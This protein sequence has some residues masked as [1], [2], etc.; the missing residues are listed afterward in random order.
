MAGLRKRGIMYYAREYDL[1]SEMNRIGIDQFITSPFRALASDTEAGNG[2]T[3]EVC[4]ANPDRF[5]ML[6]VVNPHRSGRVDADF[7]PSASHPQ[8]NGLKFHCEVHAY[9]TEGE[10][11]TWGWRTAPGK[12]M[13]SLV[14]TYPASVL[15]VVPKLADQYPDAKFIIVRHFGP[16]NLDQAPPLIHDRANVY[17]DT[18]VSLLPLGTIE[19]LVREL[20]DERI[21]FGTDM[22]YLNGGQIGKV[23]LAELDGEVKKKLLAKYPKRLFSL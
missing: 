3:L 2:E 20:G 13:P 11:Y 14:H 8:V 1:L 5:L 17:S 10:G 12:G 21:L 16:E 23:L 6:F 15:A 19:R 4:E 7:A 9:P 18:C 22:P